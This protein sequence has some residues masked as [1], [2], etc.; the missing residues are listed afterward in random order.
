M[1]LL[2]VFSYRRL[3]CLKYSLMEYAV[4]IVLP[5]YP[6]VLYLKGCIFVWLYPSDDLSVVLHEHFV[7]LWWKIN[8]MFVF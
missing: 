7:M 6:K 8:T 5:E 4:Q 3:S 1:F 2:S